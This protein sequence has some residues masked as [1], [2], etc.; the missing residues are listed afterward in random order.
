[1][2]T[3]HYPNR[4]LGN[5]LE[6]DSAQKQAATAPAHRKLRLPTHQ[7]LITYLRWEALLDSL[8]LLVAIA[9]FVLWFLINHLRWEALLVSLAFLVAI[10]SFLLFSLIIISAGRLYSFR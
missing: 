5:V 7:V 9:S 2:A 10:E 4:V 8:A 1:M 6:S 3:L